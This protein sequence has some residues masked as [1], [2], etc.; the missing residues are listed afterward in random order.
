MSI[1]ILIMFVYVFI[2]NILIQKKTKKKLDLFAKP[3]HSLMEFLSYY[4]C[5]TSFILFFC[6]SYII[7]DFML[8]FYFMGL[9][10]KK[11]KKK[12]LYIYILFFLLNI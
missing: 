6:P 8:I 10:R 1:H 7:Y 5:H 3:K 11:S 9:F 2:I 12:L 4:M